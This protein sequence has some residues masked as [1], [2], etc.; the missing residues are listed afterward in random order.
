MDAATNLAGNSY[1]KIGSD[2]LYPIYT[3]IH[4]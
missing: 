2:K 3:Y 1:K 4:I